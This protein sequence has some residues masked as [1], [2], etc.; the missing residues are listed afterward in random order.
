MT[1]ALQAQYVEPEILTFEDYMSEGEINRRYDIIDGKR[2]YMTNPS[3]L[4]QD[5]A[6]NITEA[7]RR[8]QRKLRLGRTIMAP[9]D[10]LITRKPLRTRQPD[11]LFI[12]K[13]RFGTRNLS[14]PAPLSPAPE[15]VVEVLSPSESRA[16]RAAK[17]RDY[18]KV[19]VLECWIV[20]PQAET[21]EV[22]RLTHVAHETVDI[23][24]HDATVTSITF[25]DLAIPVADIFA[26]DE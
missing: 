1:M 22:L 15:L 10:I 14:D 7:L 3:L 9:A 5:V 19:G 13:E 23:Y 12:S 24:G 4:H 26:Y 21:V 25:P 17:I 8:F 16:T 20:S 11:A 2:E 18:C 6:F